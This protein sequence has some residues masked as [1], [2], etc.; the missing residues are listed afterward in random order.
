VSAGSWIASDSVHVHNSSGFAQHLEVVGETSTR[1]LKR[2]SGA[3]AVAFGGVG[4][5]VQRNLFGD[6][7]QALFAELSVS[8]KPTPTCKEEREKTVA[9]NRAATVT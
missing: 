4:A 2:R 6:A 8:E 9:P 7:D 1:T 3:G 5:G